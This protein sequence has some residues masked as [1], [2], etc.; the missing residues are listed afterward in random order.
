MRVGEQPAYRRRSVYELV[1]PRGDVEIDVDMENIAGGCYL[2]GA[3][4]DER[5]AK[6]SAGAGRYKPFVTWDPT[7][8]E[9]ELDAFRR[10]WNW[11]SVQRHEALSA[12]RTLRAYCYSKGAENGQMRRIARLLGIDTEVEAFLQSEQWIDLYEVFSNQLVTGRP[13]G[14]KNAAPLAGFSWHGDEA[15]GSQAMVLYGTAIDGGDPGLS[16]DA[17]R[18]LLEYNEDDV[19]ATAALRN[20]LDEDARLLPSVSDLGP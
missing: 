6:N 4:I 19:R 20:W 5:H 3:L 11:L 14:L 9:G 18:W 1:V 16:T 12:G 13:M 17:R 8:S 15:G 10:F 7:I 2:W